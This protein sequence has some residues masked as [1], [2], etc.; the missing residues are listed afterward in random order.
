M[1][2]TIKHNKIIRYHKFEKFL[3][4]LGA[5]SVKSQNF[6]INVD[7][8]KPSIDQMGT[9]TINIENQKRLQVSGPI[10]MLWKIIQIDL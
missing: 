7:I 1:K 9:Y 5:K 8:P 3:Y 4:D 2:N 10:L 6:E